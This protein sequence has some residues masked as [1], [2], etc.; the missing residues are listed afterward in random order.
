MSYIGNILFNKQGQESGYTSL[1]IEEF[2][3]LFRPAVIFT[4]YL[5]NHLEEIKFLPDRE[6]WNCYSS[7][8][9][10]KFTIKGGQRKNSNPREHDPE[11][12][13]IWNINQNPETDTPVLEVHYGRILMVRHIPNEGIVPTPLSFMESL[14]YLTQFQSLSTEEKQQW[15]QEPE[16]FDARLE[17]LELQELER[18]FS[19]VMQRQAERRAMDILEEIQMLRQRI[20]EKHND[21]IR[22]QHQTDRINSI[23]LDLLS[24]KRLADIDSVTIED[25]RAIRIVTK[26]IPVR[27]FDEAL[28][29]R[30]RSN[31]YTDVEQDMMDH[32][33]AGR[34]EICCAPK[35]I[36]LEFGTNRIDYRIDFVH[37][38]IDH[39]H[40]TC[41]GNFSGPLDEAR[42]NY[43]LY[44][45]MSNLIQWFSSLA[46]DDST[47]ARSWLWNYSGFR[48]KNQP[49]T[50]IRANNQAQV[51]NLIK[52]LNQIKEE[53]DAQQVPELEDLDANLE[54]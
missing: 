26:Q 13:K 3:H 24:L 16:D 34:A 32:V 50:L 48:I 47:V 15:L 35:I 17:E 31:Y 14:A 10:L 46:F 18:G 37:H 28:Y 23:R 2:D 43:D 5:L 25:D 12:K 38:S 27:Y 44:G 22:V 11:A 45:V 7:V 21:Y 20:L 8:F 40:R 9:Y 6:P 54:L 36:R 19:K 42:M 30:Y 52:K 1:R 51:R 39:P 41:S 53:E 29:Q 33:I 4:N 49:N